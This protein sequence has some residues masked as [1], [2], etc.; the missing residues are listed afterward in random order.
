[1][2][3]IWKD[4]EDYEG[5]Y[6]VSNLG[7]VKSLKKTVHYSDGRVYSYPEKIKNQII[8]STKAYWTVTLSDN[9][10]T[11]RKKC[12]YVHV[13]VAKAFIP[14]P[15]NF[16]MVMHKDQKNLRFDNEC[17]N[18]V[19]NL[20][21]STY[22]DNASQEVCRKRMSMAG[23]GKI[24]K[25]TTREKLSK[26]GKGVAHYQKSVICEGIVYDNIKLCANYYNVNPNTMRTWLRKNIIP[27]IFKVRGLSYYKKQY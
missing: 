18:N 7:R 24:I 5:L 6:Q 27:D 21:W 14:N 9:R 19:E 1:M 23:K 17:N 20:E 3:E 16:P 25:K 11:P 8:D 12:C 26:A 2:E 15:N 13:L 10:K 4:I 22:K